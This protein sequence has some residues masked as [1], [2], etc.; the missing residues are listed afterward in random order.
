MTTSIGRFYDYP[1]ALPMAGWE[2]ISG[3]T[4]TA[5]YINIPFCNRFCYYCPFTK[6]IPK[7][8]EHLEA[9]VKGIEK[10][11]GLV[12]NSRRHSSARIDCVYIG[13]G[14][15][16]LLP[17][18][19][20]QGLIS[21]SRQ[22]FDFSE[23]CQITV[24]ANPSSASEAFLRGLA[25]M[26]ISR[27]SF[28]VQTFE[29]EALRSLGCSHTSTQAKTAISMAQSEG[30]DVNVDLLYARPG[31]TTTAWENDIAVFF[32]TGAQHLSTYALDLVPVVPLYH[33][34]N[35]G[36]AGR[37]PLPDDLRRMIEITD[38]AISKNGFSRYSIDQACVKGHENRYGLYVAGHSVIGLGAGA[39][40]YYDGFVYRNVKASVQYL[41]L[42]ADRKMP[43]EL[44]KKLT[45]HER[46]V[47][48]VAKQLLFLQVDNK[49]FESMFGM[50][51]E[52]VFQNQI[53][54][55]ERKGYV[56]ATSDRIA[57][58]FEGRVHAFEVVRM[59]FSPEYELLIQKY[60]RPKQT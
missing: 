53:C 5:L 60:E 40:S 49:V 48:Y 41:E 11:M 57:L 27:V 55:L 17:V 45:A 38:E 34:V 13:G 9:Y 37:M 22:T 4:H 28:G 58:T 3:P 39:F 20:I 32:S 1:P 19:S 24:E 59:F 21:N 16:S 29:P 50:P 7:G 31:Q 44:G 56:E 12:A 8:R 23:D 26:G 47:R 18:S 51:M 46:M 10:E 33:H 14:T 2:D 42:L 52:I 30:L 54:K 43:V 36:R 15:P 6:E 35:E 25:K